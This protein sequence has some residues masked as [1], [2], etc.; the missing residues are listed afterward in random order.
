MVA[1]GTSSGASRAAQALSVILT[2]DCNLDALEAL[3]EL[4]APGRSVFQ[5]IR[6]LGLYPP[7][8]RRSLR[9]SH[10]ILARWLAG[11]TEKSSSKLCICQF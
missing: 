6:D 4:P 2:D 5:L 10:Q 9:R 3:A 8:I 7:E 11:S 1:C